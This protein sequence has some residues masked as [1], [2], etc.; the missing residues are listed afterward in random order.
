MITL[1]IAFQYCNLLARQ[2]LYF[3]TT[4]LIV[5]SDQLI[6]IICHLLAN[7]LCRLV[8]CSVQR[9]HSGE[10]NLTLLSTQHRLRHLQRIDSCKSLCFIYFYQKVGFKLSHAVFCNNLD[11]SYE[12]FKTIKVILFV[13][14]TISDFVICAWNENGFRHVV[15]IRTTLTGLTVRCCRSK[16]LR[17][18][19]SAINVTYKIPKLQRCNL[20]LLR[21]NNHNFNNIIQIYLLAKVT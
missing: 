6:Y 20:L 3:V 13:K 9:R 11:F 19:L 5:C 17:D 18:F 21:N 8:Q 4:M 16:E 7:E 12:T 14:K 2:R 15:K 1:E 10:H